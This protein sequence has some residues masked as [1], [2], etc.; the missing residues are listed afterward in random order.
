MAAQERVYILSPDYWGFDPA[1]Q[2]TALN[3]FTNVWTLPK[4]TYDGLGEED[5]QRLYRCALFYHT[6]RVDNHGFTPI[7][8]FDKDAD[9]MVRGT[10]RGGLPQVRKY[11]KGS[12]SP[13]YTVDTIT[14]A[15]ADPS[16][17]TWDE[18]ADQ[19]KQSADGTFTIGSY[20]FDENK[21][22]DTINNLESEV[23]TIVGASAAE[24][25]AAEST[26]ASVAV[27]VSE[28]LSANPVGEAPSGS[29]VVYEAPKANRTDREGP[30]RPTLKYRMS[31]KDRAMARRKAREA[32]ETLIQEGLEMTLDAEMTANVANSNLPAVPV[33]ANTMGEDSSLS[34]NGV[35]EWY[36][37]AETEMS[38]LMTSNAFGQAGADYDHEIHYRADEM[39]AEDEAVLAHYA[40]WSEDSTMLSGNGVPTYYGSAEDEDDYYECSQCHTHWED[41]DEAD[42]CC[43]SCV[44]CGLRHHGEHE[45]A[46]ECCPCDCEPGD[47]ECDESGDCCQNYLNDFEAPMARYNPGKDDVDR[48]LASLRSR[49]SGLRVTG[50]P[51]YM[52]MRSGS[53]NKYHVFVRTNKGNFNGYGRIGY[54]PTIHGPMS[55]SEFDRKLRAKQRPSK[56]YEETKYAEADYSPMAE[57]PSP[58][59]PYSF[60]DEMTPNGEFITSDE[61]MELMSETLDGM[62]LRYEKPSMFGSPLALGVGGALVAALGYKLWSKRS[63]ST[64]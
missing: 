18:L 33:V 21:I 36:G 59:E 48:V 16:A 40:N 3:F 17:T 50:T 56:G 32:K 54:A 43:T 1:T 34:G 45:K 15:A 57:A 52:T 60:M 4:A 31:A 55:D 13:P 53:S 12:Q 23:G 49:Y 39:S 35:P 25:Y 46:Q 64:E 24:S 37:S 29:E 41:E 62:A 22:M 2:D 58:H 7:A 42:G 8:I 61:F 51:V 44:N 19:A 14:M 20:M 9:L 30:Q 5:R 38:Q 47:C 28:P 11:S 6:K 26:P 63:D 10:G 27:D